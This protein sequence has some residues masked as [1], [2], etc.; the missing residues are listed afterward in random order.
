MLTETIASKSQAPQDEFAAIVDEI[1]GGASAPKERRAGWLRRTG[2]ARGAALKRAWLQSVGRD[3]AGG[4]A[5]LAQRGIDPAL[6]DASLDEHRPIEGAKRPAWATM[7]AAMAE[8]V[9]RP[10]APYPEPITTAD[11][12][13][14]AG[15]PAGVDATLPWPWLPLMAP[16]LVLAEAEVSL[17]L[18]AQPPELVRDL[19]LALVRRLNGISVRVLISPLT[20]SDVIAMRPP[21]IGPTVLASYLHPVGA[22]GWLGLWRVYPGLARILAV[23]I[24]NWR[25]AVERLLGALE[26][27]REALEATFG[28]DLGPATGVS[29]DH[30]DTH[31][32]GQSVAIVR[33][34]KRKLAWKPRDAGPARLWESVVE[35]VNPHIAH[36][37]RAAATV[38]GPDRAWQEFIVEAAP[39]DEA[40]L[41]AYFWRIGATARLLQALGSVDFHGENLISAGEHPVLVDME[42]LLAPIPE[43][44]D[45]TGAELAAATRLRQMPARSGV[46]TVRAD[47]KAGRRGIEVGGIAP[48]APQQSP[49]TAML[50][51]VDGESIRFDPG[52]HR[53]RT[54]TALPP[55]ED[56]EAALAAHFGTIEEG[57]LVTDAALTELGDNWLP[58]D[59]ASVPTRHVVRPTRIY[60]RLI[61][62][63]QEP[64]CLRDGALRE[65]AL[66]RLWSGKFDVPPEAIAFEQDCMRD[67]DVP[68]YRAIAGSRHLYFGADGCAKDY[69]AEPALP[70]TPKPVVDAGPLRAALFARQPQ[71]QAIAIAP[72]GNDF[73]LHGPLRALVDAVVA[74][75]VEAGG[76]VTW[77]GLH[78]DARSDGWFLNQLDDSAF[79]GRAGIGDALAQAARVLGDDRLGRFAAKVLSAARARIAQRLER[80][81][82][83]PVD[84]GRTLALLAQVN[85]AAL[86][87]PATRWLTSIAPSTAADHAPGLVQA[88]SATPGAQ[89][90]VAQAR[91]ALAA[92]VEEGEDPIVT[93]SPWS[94]TLAGARFE[95]GLIDRHP[96]PLPVAER[97]GD[98]VAFARAARQQ[99]ALAEAVSGQLHPWLG[100][101]ATLADGRNRLE[102]ALAAQEGRIA[103]EAAAMLCASFQRDGRWFPDVH[104]PDAL[105][106]GAG[107][108]LARMVRLLAGAVEAA[109]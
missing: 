32:G 3:A 70:G 48:R 103:G 53:I 58:E 1:V 106:L 64:A 28:P 45:C 101:S 56:S 23:A 41:A 100:V 29:F 80:R 77:V 5:L 6:F 13:G 51:R 52:F 59:A 54:G 17:A 4:D 104:A 21:K 86:F 7:I 67:L 43:P 15:L 30:G 75:A 69:F 85:G 63:S 109:R 8:A 31:E 68:T 24:I 72:A 105:F 20:D 83:L 55:V 92:R 50:M 66:E 99:P 98:A 81:A 33:F 44:G 9:T 95:A 79:S 27:D 93:A 40:G 11:V 91:I 71:R 35:R 26:A 22:P 73:D 82:E 107:F 102:A 38:T 60:A 97:I 84:P 34:G 96:G 94:E 2:I 19:R 18:H 39:A 78:F 89:A 61:G 90:L 74:T 12:A 14:S 37:L 16:L 57:Y 25:H 42:T 47:G 49:S 62:T 46:I 10:N 108:G 76:D 87:E 88:L 36:P 65:L